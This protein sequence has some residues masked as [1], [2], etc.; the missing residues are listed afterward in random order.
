MKTISYDRK[1]VLLTLGVS[2][3][4]PK[5][6]IMKNA[7]SGNSKEKK[8]DLNECGIT[9]ILLSTKADGGKTFA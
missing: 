6:K 7:L 9:D 8:N 4:Y 5:L 2:N 1:K 3:K